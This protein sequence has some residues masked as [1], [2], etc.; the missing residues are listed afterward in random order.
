MMAVQRQQLSAR[1]GWIVANRR[2]WLV[3]GI[4]AVATLDPLMAEGRRKN[5]HEEARQAFQRGEIRSLGD[6]YAELQ[7]QVT[8]QVIEVELKRRKD[9]YVYEFKLLAPSGK[10]LEIEFDAKTGKL[11]SSESN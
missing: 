5:D 3:A 10:V 9:G 6:I 1:G 8:G 7:S 11:I 2:I 4:L